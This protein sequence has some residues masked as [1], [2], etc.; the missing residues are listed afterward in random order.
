[1]SD[2]KLTLQS[3]NN[4][5]QELINMANELPDKV[6]GVQLNFEVVGGLEQ[7]TNPTENMIWVNTDTEITEWIFSV[8]EPE[9]P[10]EG[11]VWVY[12]GTASIAEFNALKNNAIQVYPIKAK[13]YIGDAWGEKEAK[14]YRGEAWVEL[15]VFLYN[16]GNECESIS[17]GWESKAFAGNAQLTGQT[18]T[19]TKLSDYMDISMSESMSGGVAIHEKMVDLKQFSTVTFDISNYVKTNSYSAITLNVVDRSNNAVASKAITEGG[20]YSL[21]ISS[22]DGQH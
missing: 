7:P 3:H 9:I 19:I 14:T 4:D 21:D 1:M 8:T 18:P 16:K 5:L 10:V 13:Q 15:V 17:G 22:L 11:M 6:E 20:I 2:Y 12:S